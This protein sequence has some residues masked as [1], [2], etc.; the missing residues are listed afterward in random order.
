[1]KVARTVRRIVVVTIMASRRR[2]GCGSGLRLLRDGREAVM[3]VAGGTLVAGKKMRKRKTLVTS[4]ARC[5]ST[6]LDQGRKD[7][8]MNIK[9]P[10]C[11]PICATPNNAA[12]HSPPVTSL[13]HLRS[14]RLCGRTRM[15]AMAPMLERP[16]SRTHQGERPSEERRVMILRC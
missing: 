12:A 14:A 6:S 5:S 10:H 7:T 2:G 15:L 9:H 8:Y 4:L 16:P 13:Q 1:M 3:S 11:N